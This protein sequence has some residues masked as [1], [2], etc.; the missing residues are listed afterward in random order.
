MKRK[1][2][3]FSILDKQF[4]LEGTVSAKGQ[5]IIKGTV[6]GTL[7]GEN[8]I[9]AEEGAVHAE[10]EVTRMTIGGKFEG[11]VR[12]SQE[13]VILS[14]GRCSGKIVCRDFVVEAGG[15]LNAEVSCM[16]DTL[17]ESSQESTDKKAKDSR[18]N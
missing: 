3:S 1:N 18:K 16:V 12:A 14:T 6:Q 2:K 13:L 8:V 17:T 9:I 7:I 4:S 5:L 15:V 11:F 10:A